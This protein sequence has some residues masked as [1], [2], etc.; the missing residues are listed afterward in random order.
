MLQKTD[1]IMLFPVRKMLG[2]EFGLHALFF[3]NRT[4]TESMEK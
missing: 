1:R 4:L 2:T 3:L